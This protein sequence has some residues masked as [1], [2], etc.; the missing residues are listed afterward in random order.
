MIL[1]IVYIYFWYWYK[2]QNSLKYWF[3]AK[4]K[5][6]I[7]LEKSIKYLLDNYLGVVNHLS[8]F[9]NWQFKFDKLLVNLT[10]LQNF[11]TKFFTLSEKLKFVWF[12]LLSHFLW[13]SYKMFDKKNINFKIIL[14]YFPS[15]EYEFRSFKKLK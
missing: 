2:N 6:N 4:F 1:I 15:I 11:D 3:N 9:Y 13:S 5:Q 8:N 14:Q 12:Y 7:Y 10:N